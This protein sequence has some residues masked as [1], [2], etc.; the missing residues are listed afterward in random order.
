MLFLKVKGLKCRGNPHAA[1]FSVR[2]G[3][4]LGIA[5]LVGSGRTATMR[6]VFGADLKD[7]GKIYLKDNEIS[8]RKPRD[9]VGNGIC[10][11]TED[12]KEQGLISDMPCYVNITITDLAQV[13]RYGLLENALEKS[14]SKKLVDDLGIKMSSLDQ[15]VSNLSGG[16]QQKVVL[17]K[18]L[19]RDAD[20]LIFDEPTRGIDVGAKY[21]I[22]LL[23]WKLANLGKAIILVSSDLPEILGICHRILV[24]SNGKITGEV[25]R[26]EFNQEKILA[27][28]YQEYIKPIDDEQRDRET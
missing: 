1:S 13:S 7:S 18:W 15:W 23:L 11:L 3:E 25:D 22:Y 12:R 14:I 20:V 28:A 17:A 19:F 8:I 27:M 24:F 16:N 6:A 21:E 2:K 5:G 10:L 9:A 26:K 4:L